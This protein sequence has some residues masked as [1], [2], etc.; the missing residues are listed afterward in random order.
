MSVKGVTVFGFTW[1]AFVLVATSAPYLVN[2]FSTP[3]GY[4]YTWIIPPYPD[5]SFGLRGLG[6]NRRHT[7]RGCLRSSSPAVPH[8]PFL[9]HPFFLICGRLS[10]LFSCD[11]GTAFFAVKAIGVVLFFAVFYRYIDYLKLNTTASVVAT[12]S[13]GFTL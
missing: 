5:D 11:V 4:H 1:T 8:A 12:I 9:F 7:E 13:L 10:A 6:R 2:F 3:S